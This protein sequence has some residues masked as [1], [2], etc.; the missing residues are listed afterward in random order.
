VPE[1]KT[2]GWADSYTIF[3]HKTIQFMNKPEN[4]NG[5]EKIGAGECS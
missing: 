4:T 3:R 5:G 2:R 1:L